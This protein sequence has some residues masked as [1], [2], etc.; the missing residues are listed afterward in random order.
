M[1]GFVL[2][3]ASDSYRRQR[4]ALLEAEEALKQQHETVARMR[5]ELPADTEVTKDYRFSRLTDGGTEEVSLGDLFD[6]SG[7]PLIVIHFMWKPGDQAPCPMCAMWADGYAASWRHVSQRASF[8]A[9]AK[10]E[11]GTF[12]QL[13]SERGW[14]DLPV[15]SSG[16]SDFNVDFGMQTDDGGQLPGISVF[17]K[18]DGGIFHTYT[19]S[20]LI[21]AD[22]R[23]GLDHLNPTWNLFDLLPDGRGEFFPKLAY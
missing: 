4:Q 10:Q 11:V 22:R 9:V 2:P 23:R 7:R 17:V 3:H 14:T 13:A 8:V 6:D 20:A 16:N 12:A 18:R 1:E 15:V 19:I 5:R 21:G